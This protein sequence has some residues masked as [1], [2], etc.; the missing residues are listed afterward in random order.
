MGKFIQIEQGYGE[1]LTLQVRQ[2]DGSFSTGVAVKN[3]LAPLRSDEIQME[4]GFSQQDYLTMFTSTT[5]H[6]HDRIVR[7]DGSTWEV[8]PPQFYENLALGEAFYVATLRRV[9]T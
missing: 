1:N 5:V 9:K 2:A 6:L 3:I 7:G 4:A 8:G